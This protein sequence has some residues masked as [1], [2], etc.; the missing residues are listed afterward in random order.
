[1]N[2]GTEIFGE[3]LR[4]C[5]CNI[6][7]ILYERPATIL[8][9]TMFRYTVH[10][11]KEDIFMY[12]DIDVFILKS[13]PIFTEALKEDTLYIHSE[14]SLGDMN[15]GAAFSEQELA[16]L[17]GSAGFNS[18]KFLIRGKD[19][20]KHF[21]NLVQILYANCKEKNFL[22]LDQPY[23]NKAIYL[24]KIEQLNIELLSSNQTTISCN[25]RNYKKDTTVLF[26][27]LGEAGNGTFHY[28]KISKIFI[29][30]QAGCL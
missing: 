16:N 26:D 8:E 22:C 20:L 27:M 25:G 6:K 13:L 23:F 10:D 12:C 30:F 14:G 17:S 4:G 2:S 28:T 7:I 19:L 3:L 21:F 11:Y 9:G 24:M 5:P 29:L 15:Y 1:M 18:G